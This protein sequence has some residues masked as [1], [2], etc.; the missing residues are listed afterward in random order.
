MPIVIR[1]PGGPNWQNPAPCSPRATLD[2]R[3]AR[4]TLAVHE[5]GANVRQILARQVVILVR[6]VDDLLDVTRL[7]TGKIVLS[8]SPVNLSAAA[9]RGI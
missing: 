5:R 3:R 9:Q 8:S 6:L 1:E 7:A 4:Q 2:P